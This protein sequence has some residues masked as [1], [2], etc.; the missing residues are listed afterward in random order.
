MSYTS[1]S[2][3]R[4]VNCTL[5]GPVE[6]YV[7][8]NRIVRVLPLRYGKD[9]AEP[10]TIEARGQTFTRPNKASIACW[11]QG[12]KQYVYSKDRLL[13]PLK[14]VDFDPEGARNP[15]K[16]GIS[17][18]EPISWDRALEITAKEIM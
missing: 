1:K 17:G 8:D 16:R 12:T 2:E 11:V 13:T 6:V 14:R 5:S 18:Y 7:K 4:F 9:D 10:W 15:E 3:H